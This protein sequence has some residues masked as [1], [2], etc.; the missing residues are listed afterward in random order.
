MF[1]L[2]GSQVGLFTN[3]PTAWI[4]VR[5]MC[6]ISRVCLH[7]LACPAS[8]AWWALVFPS[9]KRRWGKNGNGFPPVPILSPPSFWRGEHTPQ[10]CVCCLHSLLYPASTASC[11]LPP[12]RTVPAST[13][14]CAPPLQ[15]T[16]FVCSASTAEWV[17]LIG[18]IV[19]CL[20]CLVST[21]ST[22]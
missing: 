15:P 21:A 11:T 17:L 14:Y 5:C 20:Q 8:T 3:M 2:E 7:S 16:Q 9:P 19:S 6:C 4:S 18:L 22:D 10:H 13:A 12:Q 1:F